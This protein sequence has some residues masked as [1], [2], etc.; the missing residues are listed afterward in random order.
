MISICI[1]RHMRTYIIYFISVY[2]VPYY[3]IFVLR[4]DLGWFVCQKLQKI[5]GQLAGLVAWGLF[6]GKP[7]SFHSV[8]HQIDVRF[9]QSSQREKSTNK[10]VFHGVNEA[11][12]GPCVSEMST[13]I[14]EKALGNKRHKLFIFGG[15]KNPVPKTY[16]QKV[17]NFF[18]TYLP[19]TY[20]LRLKKKKHLHPL[21]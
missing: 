9:G 21:P 8:S 6:L 19:N 16:Q 13:F 5:A 2:R 17:V 3:L 1:Y 7:A 11:M 14:P 10:H 12:K 15:C 4:K 18:G 20:L